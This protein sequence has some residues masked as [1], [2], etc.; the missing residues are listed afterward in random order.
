METHI[1]NDDIRQI[2]REEIEPL[3]REITVL[4]EMVIEDSCSEKSNNSEKKEWPQ[5]GDEYF[6]I[7]HDKE[8][9]YDSDVCCLHWDDGE[10]PKCC[11]ELG[12]CFK[13]R[14]EAEAV[15]DLRM[16]EAKCRNIK[17]SDFI[18]LFENDDDKKYLKVFLEAYEVAWNQFEG[19]DKCTVHSTSV[20]K[21]LVKLEIMLGV[22]FPTKE[23]AQERADILKRLAK[24]RVLI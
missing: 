8:R 24:I 19:D 15:R 21:S 5:E 11:Y 16:H 13:T 20:H 12:K 7:N 17:P 3:Q 9:D 14:E 22:K 10:F 23:L 1:T 2:V 4:K 6:F 18:E